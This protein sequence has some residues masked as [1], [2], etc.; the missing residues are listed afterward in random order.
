M[1]QAVARI[2]QGNWH[3]SGYVL[4]SAVGT[5]I[6]APNLRLRFKKF[7]T[8]IDVRYIR[9]HDLRHTVAFLVLN[10]ANVPIEKASQALGHTRIDTTKQIYAGH[11]P[12]YNDDFIAGIASVLPTTQAYPIS[13]MSE[14]RADGAG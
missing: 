2:S 4:T 14:Q 6:S 12:R 7:L 13:F 1:R 3:N 11:V 10:D 5:P 9:P 8:S